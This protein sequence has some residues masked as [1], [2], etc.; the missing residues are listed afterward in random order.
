MN[1]FRETILGSI[2]FTSLANLLFFSF[3]AFFA[4]MALVARISD[5]NRDA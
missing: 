3:A 5:P 4:A 2:S 1:L